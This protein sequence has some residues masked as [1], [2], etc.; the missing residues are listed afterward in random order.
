MA[1]ETEVKKPTQDDLVDGLQNLSVNDSPATGAEGGEKTK[2]P[3]KRTNKK[4]TTNTDVKTEA[5]EGVTATATTNG[6]E[7]GDGDVTSPAS[8]APK[9][10]NTAKVF[11][12]NLPF[13]V[14]KEELEVAFG[15]AGAIAEVNVITRGDRSMGFGFISFER[16]ED[17][18]KAVQLLNATDIGGRTISVERAQDKDPNEPR[19]RRGG[20]RGRGRGVGRGRGRGGRGAFRGRGR[21][22]FSEEGGARVDQEEHEYTEGTEGHDGEAGSRSRG[23]GRGSRGGR[24]RGASR[25]PRSPRDTTGETSKTTIFVA[26]LPFKVDDEDLA[27]I[28]KGYSV[29]SVHV[30]KLRNG[31]SK[32][33]GF[34]ELAN[35]AEQHKVL[36]ELKNIVVDGRE[37]VIK[38]AM[39]YQTP[40]SKEEEVKEEAEQE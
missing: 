1:N 15:N 21:G 13:Q 19:R 32:G 14:T 39:A 25:T 26:N 37:L 29:A 12:G 10:D 22:S 35:E 2:K 36:Q 3:R 17:A 27:S 34:V 9:Y 8:T 18:D 31:R 28:F 16:D 30:V 38:V 20:F 23:R 5:E 40:P 11:V 7:N 24:G 4:K 33:F 6:D